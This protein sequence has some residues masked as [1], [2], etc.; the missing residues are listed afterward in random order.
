MAF[1][2]PNSPPRTGCD[3]GLSLREAVLVWIQMF[4]S[5]LAALQRLEILLYYLALSCDVKKW[6]HAFLNVIRAILQ[7]S[8]KRH[9]LSASNINVWFSLKRICPLVFNH[10]F[11]V[12]TFS[13]IQDDFSLLSDSMIHLSGHFFHLY[14]PAFSNDILPNRKSCNLFGPEVVWKRMSKRILFYS[15]SIFFIKDNILISFSQS[16]KKEICVYFLK[17]A[18]IYNNSSKYVIML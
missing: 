15:V 16:L 17:C 8:G 13:W 6:V 7:V 9:S 18:N 3:H 11:F 10:I 14:F 2:Y 12:S 1:I 4:P 5:R